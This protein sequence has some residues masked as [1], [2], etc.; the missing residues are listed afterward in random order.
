LCKECNYSNIF[1]RS[2]ANGSSDFPIKLISELEDLK[3][4][5]FESKLNYVE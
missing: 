1:P 2:L 3:D 4:P 5:E